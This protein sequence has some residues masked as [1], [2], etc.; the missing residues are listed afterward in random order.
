MLWPRWDSSQPRRGPTNAHEASNS[1]VDD[2]N[3]HLSGGFIQ[4]A[5]EGLGPVACDRLHPSDPSPVRR[6]FVTSGFRWES[7][8]DLRFCRRFICVTTD[9]YRSSRDPAAGRVLPPRPDVRVGDLRSVAG[10]SAQRFGRAA[11]PE[12]VD[13]AG[14][15]GAARSGAMDLR[16]SPPK[17]SR[18]H[19]APPASETLRS[20][21]SGAAAA[22]D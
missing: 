4:H 7:C 3:P 14:G 18:W 5:P 20:S 9:H 15:R 1:A 2:R 11:T 19:H 16:R 12:E 13:L 22:P 8:V 17:P 21:R 6:G 10:R